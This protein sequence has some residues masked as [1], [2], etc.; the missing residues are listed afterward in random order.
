MN[1][2]FGPFIGEFGWELC[3][4]HGWLRMIKYKYFKT[5][6]KMF[7]S[8]FPGR[9]PLYEFA[10]KFIPVP[11]WYRQNNFSES[12]FFIDW[13]DYDLIEQ[14]RIKN[15]M[16]KLIEYYKDYFRDQDVTF[17]NEYPQKIYTQKLYYRIKRQINKKIIKKFK[18][19][20]KVDNVE[21]YIENC[22][23]FAGKLLKKPIFTNF[24]SL[25]TG[26]YLGQVPKFS[27]QKFVE[28]QPTSV[29]EDKKNELLKNHNFDYQRPVFTIFPRKRLIRRPDK[30]W[31]EENWLKFIS[32]LIKK[33]NPLIVLCGTKNGSFLTNYENNKNVIN[34][35]NEKED[36]LM[37]LQLAFIKMCDISVHG[38]SGSIYLSMQSNCP[39]ILM[40]QEMERHRCCVQ[41]NLLN[42]SIYF[43]SEY[44]LKPPPEKFFEK[45]CEYYDN[46][47]K[48]G[49][50]KSQNNLKIN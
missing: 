18:K 19:E 38:K 17:I 6:D 46:L 36:I 8:S 43:Y 12:G 28:L 2:F 16:S 42:S 25:R 11:D 32:Y 5:G 15:E 33:Y 31:T 9:Y 1:Y 13:E 3:Y 48:E 45:F 34:I 4:W 47:A 29:A 41:E 30:N 14:K 44:D 10:D 39:T 20:N 22:N 21:S 35:I 27:D 40:G 37:D 23:S 24:P 26:N 7:V 50:I 49:L